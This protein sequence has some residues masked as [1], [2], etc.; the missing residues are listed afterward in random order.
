[1]FSLRVLASVRVWDGTIFRVRLGVTFRVKAEVSVGF[2]LLLIFEK[3][4]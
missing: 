3:L 2:S 4:F 1:M